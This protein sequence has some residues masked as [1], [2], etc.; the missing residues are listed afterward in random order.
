MLG[1]VFG[2]LL[3]ALSCLFSCTCAAFGNFADDQI[4]SSKYFWIRVSNMMTLQ[5]KVCLVSPWLYR[6]LQLMFRSKCTAWEGLEFYFL[7][8]KVSEAV[9]DSVIDYVLIKSQ[10]GQ[11]L[12][13]DCSQSHRNNVTE[14]ITLIVC[15]NLVCIFIMLYNGIKLGLG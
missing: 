3:C 8:L 6:S 9:W 11:E 13:P 2:L 7:Y 4:R 15:H 5:E 1:V 14:W 12:L 10:D